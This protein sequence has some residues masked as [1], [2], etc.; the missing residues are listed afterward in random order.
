MPE[1]SPFAGKRQQLSHDVAT[2]VREMIISGQVREGEFLRIDMLAK[3]LGTSSTPVREGLLL[4]QSE[5]FVRLV[6][7]R[8]FVVLGFSQQD[9]RDIF[10]AQS[11]LAGELARRA[12][13]RM[14]EEEFTEIERLGRAYAETVADGRPDSYHQIGHDFH[15]AI[16]RAA[17]STRLAMM[18][19]M[20]VRQLPNRFYGMVEGQVSDTIRDHARLVE[21][22][23]KR[24]ADEAERR[25]RDHIAG[26]ADH[27]IAHLEA[28]GVW[29][30]PAT[31]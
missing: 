23:R 6:P 21:A 25:M 9:V 1:D 26:G 4:L 8:G 22:M 10:W 20:M 12:T 2:H 27:L 24:D 18:L 19:G 7:R 16:N 17:C 14:T 11:L 28:E 30:E 31:G 13:K 5:S 3:K 29:R 15:R